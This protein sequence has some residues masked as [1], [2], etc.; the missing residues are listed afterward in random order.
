MKRNKPIKIK[1][2]KYNLYTKKKSTAAKVWTVI[3]MVVLVIGLCVLGFGLGRPIVEYFQNKDNNPDSGTSAW[4]PPQTTTSAPQTEDTSD[5]EGTSSQPEPEVIEQLNAYVLPENAAL[6]IERLN[7][8]IAIAKNKGCTSVVV[9]F[10]DSDGDYMYLTEIA[11]I[12]GTPLVLGS[13]TAQQIYDTVEAAG[14]TPVASFNT[15]KDHK[16]GAYLEGIRYLA[17]EGWTWL[18]DY[19]EMGGKSWLSPFEPN[20]AEFIASITSEIAAAGF[21]Q[22]ILCDTV[23]P[24][25]RDADYGFL[26]NIDNTAMRAERL[27]NVIDASR[28][29]AQEAGAEILVESDS[30]ALFAQSK[31]STTAEIAA[32][33][34]RLRSVR[35]LVDFS[36]TS[37]ADAKQFIGRMAATYD[38]V[39]YDVKLSASGVAPTVADEIEKAFV[40]SNINVFYE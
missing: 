36:G 3:L 10:K 38:G 5:T 15:L 19:A 8:A 26:A 16:S 23:Y 31:L 39:E 1:H 14:M 28:T 18:D 24:M 12:K 33:P 40:E 11:G 35:L 20:T 17:T 21:K 6:T 2:R 22:I 4:T 25:F 27:W 13:L 7:S 29:A 30:E 9:T 32:S 34:A 37:Y